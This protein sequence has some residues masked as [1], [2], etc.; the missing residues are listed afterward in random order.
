VTALTDSKAKLIAT[1]SEHLSESD[2]L[3]GLKAIRKE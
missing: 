2:Q 1:V 3:K